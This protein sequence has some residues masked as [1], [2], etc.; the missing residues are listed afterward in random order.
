FFRRAVLGQEEF[1]FPGLLLILSV[2][3]L[4]R[5]ILNYRSSRKV[6]RLAGLRMIESVNSTT[7]TQN[8]APR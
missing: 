5:L 6:E 8:E 1:L 2:M 3:L 7:E 4:V